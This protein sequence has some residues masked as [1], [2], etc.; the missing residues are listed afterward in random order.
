MI[1]DPGA[2]VPDVAVDLGVADIHIKDNAREIIY[3]G[4]GERT[5]V[6]ELIDS[7]TRGMT[8]G[9]GKPKGHAYAKKV[10]SERSVS[11]TAIEAGGVSRPVRGISRPKITKDT[12]RMLEEVYEEPERGDYTKDE[13]LPAPL[14]VGKGDERY[15]DEAPYGAYGDE[16][17]NWLR[18][19]GTL[20][21]KKP[22]NRVKHKRTAPVRG[23]P[24]SMRQVRL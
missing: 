2:S 21:K 6:G 17:P 8:I 5:N 4:K 24:T 12:E 14:R 23:N 18:L 13:E 11:R 22:V 15:V 10:Y 16:D 20:K 9:G 7:P 19:D 1:G 3:T